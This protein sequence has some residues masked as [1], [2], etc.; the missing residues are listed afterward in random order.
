[1]GVVVAGRQLWLE[2]PGDRNNKALLGFSLSKLTE[3]EI[4]DRREI[5]HLN[6]P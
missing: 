2:D 1:M 5:R 4:R 3:D 6:F